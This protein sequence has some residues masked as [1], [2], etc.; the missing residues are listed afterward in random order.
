MSSDTKVAAPAQPEELPFQ[1]VGWRI[2]VE[3]FR[4]AE[5]EGIIALP[6]ETVEVQKANEYRGTVVSVGPLA[7]MDET[8]FKPTGMLN[9]GWCK[10]GDVVAYDARGGKRMFADDGREFRVMN[11]EDIIARITDPNAMKNPY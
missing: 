3:P 9:P 2:I 1:A 7:Y 8:K 6:T 5:T 11:D 4:P 10:A